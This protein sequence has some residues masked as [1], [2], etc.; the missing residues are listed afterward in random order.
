MS[1][2]PLA[3]GLGPRLVL[4]SSAL[5]VAAIV[6]ACSTAGPSGFAND[7]GPT[8]SGSG[9][10]NDSSSGGPGAAGSG[11]M[12]GT[13]GGPAKPS[14]EGGI[15][16]PVGLTCNVSCAGGGTT[17]V[18][19]KVYDP[20]GS[21]PLY[22]V[23]VYVPATP[24]VPLPKG[25]PTGA[26]S[27]SCGA[28]FES[29][30]L[31][32]TTTAVDGT[33]TLTNVPVGGSVPLV[34]QVGK[35][36]R[37]LSIKVTACQDNA[38]P[39]KS[40]AF[41]GTVPST[42]TIDSMPDIAVSTGS[43]DTLECLLIRMGIASA[44]YVP[45]NSTAGHVH[46]FSGGD[47]GTG[48][49]G[50]GAPEVPPM[51][52]APNSYKS[53]WDS[54][55]DMM[56]YDVV[57]LSCEGDETYNSNSAVLEQYLNAGGRAFG[58]HFHYAWFGGDLAG[59]ENVPAPPSDW[60]SN[61]ADWGA[62]LSTSTTGAAD[63]V[64][65]L[66]GS[67]SPF[68]KGQELDQWLG[69]VGAL[70]AESAPAAEVPITPEDQDVGATN[71]AQAWLVDNGWTDYL[72]FN[73]PVDAPDAPDGGPPTYCGRAVFADIHAAGDVTAASAG[74]TNPPPTG[75]ATGALSPQEKV[76]E[77]MLFDLSSC[78]LPDTVAPPVDA[79]LPNVQ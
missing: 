49:T 19:G 4:G 17:T 36:R 8:G 5:V 31:T 30:A 26:D 25:V 6:G 11:P 75:C 67:T 54:Q 65:T 14:V 55:A 76:L 32:N 59:G 12:L 53:L 7:G 20:A 66:T 39:D 71:K 1:L 38:Q 61:L 35:W 79:G 28:L 9:G 58:S 27:C 33:F 47:D 48:G 13:D 64:E 2:R 70:G 69:V 18:T 62:Q 74:D 46:V 22:N 78:V 51:S 60:G 68:P 63:V 56:P 43:A 40:L 10:G 45:G 72:S 73:T 57:L 37:Q 34:I 52:G 42:D 15:A 3:T 29:G 23:A 50:G 21:N 44:E 16:C 77:F 41:P 24:L